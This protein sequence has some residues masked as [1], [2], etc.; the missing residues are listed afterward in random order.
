MRTVSSRPTRY[1]VTY[2]RV[3][4]KC[5]TTDLALCIISRKARYISPLHIISEEQTPPFKSYPEGRRRWSSERTQQKATLSPAEKLHA[6]YR[7]HT[8]RLSINFLRIVYTSGC[9]RKGWETPTLADTGQVYKTHPKH[10]HLFSLYTCFLDFD[11]WSDK[12]GR[13]RV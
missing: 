11:A 3:K 4:A 2:I 10:A 9:R 6:T 5:S 1:V 12:E 13:K 8:T 7:Q